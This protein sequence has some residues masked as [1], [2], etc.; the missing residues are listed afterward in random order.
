MK[1]TARL[2]EAGQSLWL[3]NIT[4]TMLDDGTLAGYIDELSITGLTSN[5]TIFDK[6][7]AG[8]E[9]YDEQIATRRCADQSGRG[10]LLR[11]GDRRPAPRRRPL[12]RRSTSAPTGSTASSR[13]RSR[14]CLPTTPRRRSCRPRS[15]TPRPSAT[16]LFIKIPGDRRPGSRRSRSRSSPAFRSTSPCSSRAS[17]TSPPPTPTCAASNGGS[18]RGS[19]RTSPRSPR[20]S[21]AAGTSRS[22]DEVPAELHNRLGI[23]VGGRAYRAYRELLDSDRWQRLLN[24]GAR[25]AAP[26]LGEH[27]DQGP[28][29]LRHPLRRGA[30]LARSR[31]T[32][33][34]RSTLLAFADHG[35]VGE[36]HG[37]GRRRL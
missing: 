1:P 15:C 29:G 10:P 16:N 8:G 24:E 17:S 26:A 11:A 30:G 6:A 20:S 7:I 27:R 34:P 36:L 32:R 14:R 5:P 37:G 33:C 9:A 13:S 23:A 21:S 28:E 12:R 22:P 25:A 31:S 35:E 4:R 2:H 19:T 18:R 3:D